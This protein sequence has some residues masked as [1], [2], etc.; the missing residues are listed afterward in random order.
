M[1]NSTALPGASCQH[2]LAQP[3]SLSG[4][5][6]HGGQKVRL[7]LLPAPAGHGVVFQRDD[8]PLAISRLPARWDAVV[9]T[10]LCT[11]LGNPHGARVS[12]VEHLLSALAGCAIDNV[13]VCLDGPEVPILDGSAAGWVDLLDLAGRQAQAE[14]RRHLQLR[15]PLRVESA[16]SWA[17][18]VPAQGSRFRVSIE[19]DEP[20]IGRQQC[21]LQLSVEGYRA[22]ISRARTF[23]FA[24]DVEA[25]LA[26]GRAR[27]GSLANA[28][29]IAEGRVL[30]PEGLRWPD[31][32]VR[33]KLL[34]C[35]GDL[36]LAGGSIE[37][38]L[39][40]HRPGHALNAQILRTLFQQPDCWQWVS[41]PS[42]HL[43]QAA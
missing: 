37:G 12:T 26:S 30:N 19:F 36:Y 16:D 32:F 38:Q 22:Q 15:R 18:L 3:V 42:C 27:G 23:G 9:D 35:I 10:R 40:A 4:T 8:L 2:T 24:R 13:I 33:H 21:D 14:P 39:I 17:L 20:L 41:A 25:M 6:L 5:T 43:A 28:V 1:P 29:L 34:D 11:V 31:E 7:Q